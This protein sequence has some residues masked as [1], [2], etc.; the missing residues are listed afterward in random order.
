MDL[1]RTL[2]E[3]EDH[4]MPRLGLDVIE[5]ALYHYLFR[6]THL[7]GKEAGLFALV[8][9]GKAIGI[10]EGSTRERIRAMHEKGCIAIQE[11]SKSGHLVRVL[12]PEEIPGIVPSGMEDTPADLAS[13]DFF[14]DRK[15]VN[16]LFRREGGRCFYCLRVITLDACALDHVI[17]QVNGANHSYRN[18]V[19]ACHGC[20]SEKQALDAPTFL[21]SRYRQGL[22]SADE[23]QDRLTTLDKLQAGQLIPDL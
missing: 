12:L 9:V 3:I 2:R 4:L 1:A 14:T 18:I 21:R 7:V 19:A 8:P 11:R 22:L 23:L 20:N 10:S 6:H 5:R 15:Y 13:V 17:A 16:S